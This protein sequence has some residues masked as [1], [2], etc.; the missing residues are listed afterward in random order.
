MSIN[1]LLRG[2]SLSNLLTYLLTHL[3]TYS[4]EHSPSW[5]ANRFA[6]SQEIPAF[7]GT[8]RFITEFTTARH[9]SL[10]WARSIQS[11]PLHPTSWSSILILS[12]PLCLGLPSGLFPS[13]FPNKP[14]YT[15]LLS[16]YVLHVPPTRTILTHPPTHK[17]N[18]KHPSSD[19]LPITR[20][21]FVLCCWPVFMTRTLG[22]LAADK[23]G[24]NPVS[25]ISSLN[26]I[27]SGFVN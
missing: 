16:P 12:S 14:L 22:V 19:T 2:F 4:M 7:Y 6:A 20:L 21:S 13:G 17:Q 26:Y 3:L 8:R 11:I 23:T 10:S 25:E 5:E 24:A 1:F 18:Y 15:P 27:Y 9:L